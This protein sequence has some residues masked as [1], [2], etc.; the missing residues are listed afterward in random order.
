MGL[1][2]CKKHGLQGFREVCEHIHEEY[3]QNIYQ[4]HL[5]FELAEFYSI[6]LCDKCWKLYDLDRF[7][8]FAELTFDEFL[9][10]EEEKA[11]PMEDEWSKVYNAV[12]RRAWC[13][14]CISEIHINHA[15]KNGEPLS[16][17][18]FE[19]TLTFANQSE[20][21]ELKQKLIEKF[22]FQNQSYS[23]IP[24]TA[25]PNCEP[26]HQ[27]SPR[28]FITAGALTYPMTVSIYSIIFEDKQNEIADFIEYF[29]KSKEFNQ[30]K[31]EFYGHSV[32]KEVESS[33]RILHYD[34]H[35]N[36]LLREVNLNC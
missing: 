12:N 33:D 23:P 17:P 22:N 14:Q 34:S 3:S 26:R 21:E 1:T 25:S 29:F 35:Q 30:V 9:D 20:I 19:K 7:K 10:M 8:K 2:R 6:T 13:V 5:D 15:R 4:P 16:F 28:I 11:K 31:I 32:W 36:Q 27:S 18:I 24:H